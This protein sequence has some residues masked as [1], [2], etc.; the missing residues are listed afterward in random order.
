MEKQKDDRQLEDEALR[1]L[2]DMIKAGVR[3][4]HRQAGR[5]Y[6]G[7]CDEWVKGRECPKCGADTDAPER[8]TGCPE[9]DSGNTPHTL[10]HEGKP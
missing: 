3:E 1:V 2:G 10:T 6:C 9:C 7:M 8:A 5:R 4:A